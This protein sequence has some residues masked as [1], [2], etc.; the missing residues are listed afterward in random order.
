MSILNAKT[1]VRTLHLFMLASSLALS[2]G[3]CGDLGEV[4]AAG[5][6]RHTGVPYANFVSGAGD[7]LD[8]ELMQRFAASLGVEYQYVQADWT[9]LFPN[10][11]GRRISTKGNEITD[12]GEAPVVADIG[13]NGIT[14]LGWRAKVVNFSEPTFPTQVWLI[15]RKDSTVTPIKPSGNLQTDIA[16]V[17]KLLKDKALFCKANTCLD[18]ALYELD[19]AGCQTLLFK[20]SL[21]DLAPAIIHGDAE[22]TLLD[23]PDTLVALQKWPGQIKVIGPVGPVQDMSVAFPKTSPE[24]C[25]AFNAFFKQLRSSGEYDRLVGKYYPFAIR[26][27]PDFFKNKGEAKPNPAAQ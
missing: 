2:H 23:V 3:L 19:K 12:L 24:L 26:F 6:L 25:A 16:E 7:G 17:K 9:T 8:V 15:A 11:T 27:F 13:A 14:V 5:V 21:N 18:P 22:L 1:S 10:L 4:K 20:G